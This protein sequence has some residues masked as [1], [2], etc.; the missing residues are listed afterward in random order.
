[1]SSCDQNQNL[2][3][4]PSPRPSQPC[5]DAPD[6]PWHSLLDVGPQ[7]APAE[8]TAAGDA[9]RPWDELSA[10]ALT[11]ACEMAEA[12]QRNCPPRRRRAQHDAYAPTRAASAC[13]HHG[14]D[15]ASLEARFSALTAVFDK[16]REQIDS[17]NPLSAFHQHL[18]RFERRLEA[19]LA[20]LGRC[21]DSSTLLLIEAQV[22][23][24]NAEL[25]ATRKELGRLESIDGRL[26]ALSQL[27]SARH[28][29]QGE[30]LADSL[31]DDGVESLAQPTADQ[32]VCQ[33]A[34]QPQAT[35][36]RDRRGEEIICALEKLLERCIAE[37]RGD[38]ERSAA[39]LQGIDDALARI[40]ERIARIE[41]AKAGS[42]DLDESED[43]CNE[44]DRLVDAYAAGARALGQDPF[45]FALDAADY[46][47]MD[48]SAKHG[49]AASQSAAAGA[50][51]AGARLAEGTLFPARA[52]S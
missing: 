49:P 14:I 13:G 6:W 43:L 28:Q 12:E 15:P 46:V 36:G 21:G 25:A 42:A 29:R 20:N 40:F 9:D 5:A 38:A 10:E 44:S 32:T 17:E 30:A 19:A 33:L 34:P 27:V 7:S 2:S 37:R 45:P 1:M 31:S 23:D 52:Q 51:E 24:L 41:E 48:A 26:N 18:A 16:W 8:T 22:G 50:S 35:A 4:H 47:A 3:P 39:V 11:R